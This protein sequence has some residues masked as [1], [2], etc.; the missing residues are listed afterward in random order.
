MCAIEQL[1]EL[2]LIL[3]LRSMIR[4]LLEMAD[5][6]Y[7]EAERSLRQAAVLEQKIPVVTMLGSAHLLLACL[8]VEMKRPDKALAE[9]K[10]I[11]SQC[12]R[13]DTPGFILK[14]GAIVIPALQLAV[15]RS[16]HAPFAVHLLDLLGASKKPWPAFVPETGETLTPR[17]V[18]VLRLVAAG[19]TNRAIAEQLVFSKN[20]AKTHVYHIFQKLGVSSR[21]QAAARAQDL[22]IV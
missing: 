5:Q 18:E 20:T 13:E 14:E 8:Y 21:V 6:R 4:G 9:L 2:P 12:E 15:E 11:L 22:G 16:V 17:E 1:Y 19:A 10:P 7:A 3:G